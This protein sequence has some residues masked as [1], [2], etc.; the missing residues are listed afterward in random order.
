M[1]FTLADWEFVITLNTGHDFFVEFL[2]GSTIIY[3]SIEI[4]V[5]MFFHEFIAS[6][7]SKDNVLL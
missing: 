7:G 4:S 2:E 1:G 5:K 3:K 6:S